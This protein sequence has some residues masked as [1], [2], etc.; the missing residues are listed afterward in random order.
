MR[1]ITWKYDKERVEQLRRFGFVVPGTTVVYDEELAGPDGMS[2]WLVN[3]GQPVEELDKAEQYLL[4]QRD[5]VGA[6]CVIGVEE[7]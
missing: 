2:F 5:V 3:E 7:Q 6:I 4:S 1:F